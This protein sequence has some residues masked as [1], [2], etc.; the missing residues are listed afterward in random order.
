MPILVTGCAGFIGMHVARALLARGESVVGVDSLNDYYD[1]AL[2]L[3]RLAELEKAGGHFTFHRL[4]FADAEA[5]DAALAGVEIDRIIHLG[6]QAG[7]RYSLESPATYIRSNL[8]GHANILE[9]ARHRKVDHLVYASSSS[10]Y[11]GGSTLPMSVDARAD[12]PLSL[13]AATKRADELLSESY[14]HLFALPQTGLRFF[15]VYGPWGRPDMA[16]WLFTDAVLA[17]RPIRL[18]NHGR[19]RR[20]FTFIDDIVDGIIRV[21]DRP[22]LADG[23][24]KPGGSFS[25][26]AVYNIGNSRSEELG[27]LVALIEKATGRS[28]LVEHAEMQPGDMVDTYADTAI[29]TRDTGFAART[30]L[31]EGVPQFVQWFRSHFDR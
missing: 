23:A 26:H 8:V 10:V 25:P 24:E 18:F 9:L 6:A 17:E 5:L 28:A 22:P 20:D 21:I 15:T 16:M 4:D 11:G 30:G 12:R 13:Y 2:K 29:T 7:V 19:M 1:P 27:K 3:A 31:D 14:A